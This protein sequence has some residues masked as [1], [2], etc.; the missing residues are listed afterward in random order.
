MTEFAE[1]VEQQK[2][3]IAKEKADKNAVLHYFQKGAGE[4]YRLTKFE[5]GREEIVYFNDEA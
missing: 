2:E 1:T 5:S 3:R 4:H